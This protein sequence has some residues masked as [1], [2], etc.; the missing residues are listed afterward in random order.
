MYRVLIADDERIE[1]IILY[2]MLDR[3]LNGRCQV[4]QAG[5][6]REALE[7]YEREK[8]QIAILDIEMPGVNGI[9][10]ARTIR[11]KDAGCSIIFLTAFDEFSYARKA[12]TVRALD[13]LL[14]PCDEKELMLVMEEAIRLAQERE[15]TG[16]D[17]GGEPGLVEGLAAQGGEGAEESGD[18]RMGKVTEIAYRYIQQNYKRDISMQDLAKKMNYSEAYFCK[19]FKQCFNKNFTAYLTEYRVKEAKKMLEQPTINVK[20]VGKAVG[21]TDSNYFTRVFK[22]VTGQTPTEYRLSV[23]SR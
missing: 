2:Q 14:K 1:R 6:G 8:V 23:F 9:E 18:A 5:N 4:F 10:A 11:E 7:V 22:R 3:N 15:R 19:L 12:I 21:Y 20:D 13:Y 17:Y 16:A